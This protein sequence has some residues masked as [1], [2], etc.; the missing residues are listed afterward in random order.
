[1]TGKSLSVGKQ[2]LS[3]LFVTQHGPAALKGPFLLERLAAALALGWPLL[4]AG[5]ALRS[6]SGWC[7][8]LHTLGK[9]A[10]GG[11]N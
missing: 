3:G 2:P 4:G 5:R 6:V 9:A 10:W 8:R 11:S 7:H 1:M